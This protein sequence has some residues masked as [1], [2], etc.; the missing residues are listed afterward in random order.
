MKRNKG[1]IIINREIYTNINCIITLIIIIRILY[2]PGTQL[3]SNKAAMR[4]T[5]DHLYLLQELS[6][7]NQRHLFL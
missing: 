7:F 5:V 6:L 3:P 4:S 1:N 2:Y